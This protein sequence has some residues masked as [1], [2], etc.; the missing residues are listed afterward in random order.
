M[1]ARGLNVL[2][3]GNFEQFLA[4][5]HDASTLKEDTDNALGTYCRMFHEPFFNI[6]ENSIRVSAE[7]LYRWVSW[8]IYYGRSKDEYP[9]A[10]Q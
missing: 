6:E 7:E 4:E 3:D 8:C 5:D 1:K 2:Y 9:L 10:N